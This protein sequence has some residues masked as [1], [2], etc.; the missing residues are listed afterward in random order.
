[1][2]WKVDVCAQLASEEKDT[3]ADTFH[4]SPPKAVYV[5]KAEFL[6]YL[7][8]KARNGTLLSEQ[9]SLS[10]KSSISATS[11]EAPAKFHKMCQEVNQAVLPRGS[12][13]ISHK[14]MGLSR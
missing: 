12:R 2:L 7:K 3:Q 8:A 10:M 11:S 9:A 1:M 6:S 5:Q 14:G 13:R 4:Q